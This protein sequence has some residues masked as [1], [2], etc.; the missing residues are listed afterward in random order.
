MAENKFIQIFQPGKRYQRLVDDL[1]GKHQKQ[2][3]DLI[4]KYKHQIEIQELLAQKI[5]DL[6]AEAD[7]SKYRGNM[8]R[9]YAKAV[10]EIEKKYLA[11]A[12]WGVVMTGNIIDLRSAFIIGNGLKIRTTV[13]KKDAKEELKWINDFMAY[14]KLDREMT[15]E[16]AKEAEIEGKIAIKLAVEDAKGWRD[17]KKMISVRYISWLDS[18]YDIETAENDYL[19]YKELVWKP[20]GKKQKGADEKLEASEFVYNKFGGRIV[21]PNS[22]Q[23]KIMKCLTQIDDVDKAL[24]DWREINWHF[25]SPIPDVEADDKDS[26]KDAEEYLK[27]INWR[28]KK[29]FIHA[30]SK[31]SYKG[32]D[33]AGVESLKEEII[34]KIKI[35]SGN[36]AMPIH[37]LGLLDLLKNRSTGE[38]T[39][40]MVIAGTSKERL[41]WVGTYAEIIEKAMD[42]F[43]NKVNPKKSTQLDS[44]KLSVNIPVY[45][46][47]QWEHLEKVLIPLYLG[48][49]IS[50]EYLLSQI[51]E[52]DVDEELERQQQKKEDE[53][54]SLK[55]QIESLKEELAMAKSGATGEEEIP[56][57]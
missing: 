53:S 2:I 48:G 13:P 34:T 20:G 56:A 18:R 49:A 16:L 8:Y 21:D 35:I 47:E 25:A 33:M 32:P 12:D 3:D 43:N 36:T 1:E 42:L 54:E 22:A 28:I 38:N 17:H 26:A 24:R 31:F 23:P 30:K 37:F 6:E 9:S 39:R 27:K 19:N 7:E 52:M 4:D 50:I 51:P 15:Q 5:S 55:A 40:E 29:G 46:A 11:T 14:N 45:T 10:K 44:S 41:I 57:E